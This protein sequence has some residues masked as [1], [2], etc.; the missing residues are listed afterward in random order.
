MKSYFPYLLAAV[1]VG[2]GG[3]A[4]LSA[5]APAH[6]QAQQ[7]APIT[8]AESKLFVAPNNQVQQFRESIP[9]AKGQDKL[10]LVLTYYNGTA[11]KPGFNWLRISSPTMSYF[12]EKQFDGNKSVTVDVTGQLSAGG[13]QIGVEGA[14][15]AGATFGWRLTTVAPSITEIRPAVLDPGETITVSGKNFSSDPSCNV[16]TVNGVALTCISATAKNLVFKVPDDMRVGRGNLDLKVAG[17]EAGAML[18][19]VEHSVLVIQ[20]LGAGWVYPGTN[21]VINGGPFSSAVRSVRVTIGPFEAPV[22]ASTANSITVQAPEQFLG[23]PW[24]VNQPVKV[25]VNGMPAKNFLT[26]NCY[27][28]VTGTGFVQ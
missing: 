27:Q 16:A 24:G 13:N 6:A 5:S 15:P 9:L 10:T 25:W 2:T 4:S 8:L 21:L 19:A 26:V 14:G 1:I 18:V 22:V 20:S 7:N 23:N 17:L 12:T 28:G 3:L 11:T